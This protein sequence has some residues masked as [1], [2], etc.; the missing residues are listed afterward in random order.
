VVEDGV[1]YKV[2]PV[3]PSY[4]MTLPDNRPAVPLTKDRRPNSE[5][6]EETFLSCDSTRSGYPRLYLRRLLEA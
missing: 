6:G 1:T 3:A 5:L 2:F 4:H